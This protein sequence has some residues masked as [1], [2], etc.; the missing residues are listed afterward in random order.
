MTDERVAGTVACQGGVILRGQALH[1]GVSPDEIRGRLTRK[2]WVRIRR[3]AY[4]DRQHWL[5]LDAVGRHLMLC[6][7]VRARLGPSAVFSHVSAAVILGLD[8]WGA[9]LGEVHVLRQSPSSPRR[10][11]GIAHH[12]WPAADVEPVAHGD[13]LV[14]P[15]AWTVLGI[16]EVWG[17]EPGVV[18]ADCALRHMLDRDLLLETF[19]PL[20]DR[21]GARAAGRV[22]EFADGRAESVGESRSR[23]VLAHLGLPRP[24]LQAVIIDD[25]GD[26]GRVDF[27]FEKTRTIGEFDGLSKYK[28]GAN[29]DPEE[30]ARIVTREK[31]REDRLRATGAEVVR[32]VW[33]ELARSQLLA[34]RLNAAF[35]RGRRLTVQIRW[36]PR[37]HPQPSR[38]ASA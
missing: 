9:D 17:F 10:E 2:V 31:L 26:A 28:L 22:V 29:D 21:P 1:L 30:A 32:W 37:A 13:F 4:A 18:T 20:R 23:V 35:E 19:L 38:R 14:T 36:R 24:E 5:G 33:A 27:W 6:H 34:A 15:P 16:A 12:R 25:W 7:A 8:V 3:G 11:G